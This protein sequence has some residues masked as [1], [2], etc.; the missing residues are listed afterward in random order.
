VTT[1]NPVQQPLSLLLGPEPS[2]TATRG[3][4][5]CG[6]S[7]DLLPPFSLQRKTE[8]GNEDQSEYVNWLTEFARRVHRVLT[9]DGSFVLDLGGAYEK[10]TPTRSLYNFRIPI[11]FCDDLGFYLA[12][13]FYWFPPPSCQVRVI[14]ASTCA[15]AILRGVPGRGSS[16]HPLQARG[17]KSPP[18]LLHQALDVVAPSRVLI[19]VPGAAGVDQRSD[20]GNNELAGWTEKVASR[21]Y[22]RYMRKQPDG[23][24]PGN[25]HTAISCGRPCK[26]L[27]RC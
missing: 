18:E 17:A 16:A 8:Y 2:Y 25:S 1:S 12:E 13:D 7:L 4:A 20:N 14:S 23:R 15:S 9:T 6:D 27:R 5:F 11:R 21:L 22:F 3:A 26:R 24:L 19:Q 10:G